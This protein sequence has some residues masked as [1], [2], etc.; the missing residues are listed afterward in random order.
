MAISD[1]VKELFA[2]YTTLSYLPPEC[3]YY[4][5][6]ARYTV[7]SIMFPSRSE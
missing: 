5:E 6:L 7:G 4:D 1:T 2:N 3:P